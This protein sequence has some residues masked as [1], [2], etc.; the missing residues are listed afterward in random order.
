MTR[1]Y[2]KKNLINLRYYLILDEKISYNEY[3]AFPIQGLGYYFD[4]GDLKN[5]AIHSRI[6]NKFFL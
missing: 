2:L 6:T 5:K 3:Y 1:Q 4:F